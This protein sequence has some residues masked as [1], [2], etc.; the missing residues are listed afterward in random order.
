MASTSGGVMNR[1]SP[2]RFMRVFRVVLG[3]IYFFGSF[4]HVY[5]GL[6]QP[7]SYRDFSRWAPP[8]NAPARELWFVWFLPRANVLAL[9]IAAFEITV[10]ILILRGGSATR[11]GLAGA[12]GFHLA[13][14]VM[15][16]MWPYTIPMILLITWALRYEFRPLLER[17]SSIAGTDAM[18]RL[19]ASHSIQRRT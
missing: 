12:L 16:G 1:K 10:G 5:F 6:T 2:G 8:L 4:S 14:A 13:L 17:G 7:G 19:T 15:F 9:V 11:L 18:A 3:L